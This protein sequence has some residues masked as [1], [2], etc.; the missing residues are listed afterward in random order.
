M[1]DGVL[2][3]EDVRAADTAVVGGKGANLGELLAA[4]FPVPA[5]FVIHAGHAPF[6][7]AGMAR[8]VA[9]LHHDLSPADLAR[10]CSALQRRILEA[11]IPPPLANAIRQAHARLMAGSG[12]DI[13][14][15]V[16]SSATAEDLAG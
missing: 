9:G 16:R 2:P 14:C 7:T 4:G 3:L 13:T 10:R 5:G 11:E 15:V 8:D 1:K 6:E 12:T